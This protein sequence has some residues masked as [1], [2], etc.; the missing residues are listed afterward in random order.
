[1]MNS[2]LL[3]SHC[4]H[5][6]PLE[7]NVGVTIGAIFILLLLFAII[8]FGPDYEIWKIEKRNREEFKKL[9]EGKGKP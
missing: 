9:R 2:I 4:G 7:T 6:L 5:D 1:M 8:Y 3:H